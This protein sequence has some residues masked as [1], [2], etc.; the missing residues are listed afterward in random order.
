MDKSKRRKILPWLIGIGLVILFWL[1]VT[2]A[3]AGKQVAQNLQS[4]FPGLEVPAITTPE[5]SIGVPAGGPGPDSYTPTPKGNDCGCTISLCQAGDNQ[6]VKS[7]PNWASNYLS[8]AFGV[9]FD[10]GVHMNY[11]GMTPTQV[12]AIL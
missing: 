10:N 9:S 1:F 4:M 6:Q 8:D 12:Y 7:A 3:P 5:I 11:G 2:R